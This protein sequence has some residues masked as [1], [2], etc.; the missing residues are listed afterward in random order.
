MRKAF[1]LMELAIVLTIM[2]ILV[3]G[4]MGIMGSMMKNAKTKQTKDNI[5]AAVNSIVG[6]V[7]LNNNLPDQTGFTNSVKIPND[8]WSKPFVYIYPNILHDNNICYAQTTDLSIRECG[9][10]N[11]CTTYAQKDNIAFVVMSGGENYNLQ[12]T[13]VGGNP[14][15][16]RVYEQETNVDNIATPIN[17]VEPY[18]DIVKW[19]TLSELQAKINCKNYQLKIIN[20]D[21]PK[22]NVGIPYSAQLFANN[23]IQY[24]SGGQYRWCVY[25]ASSL[26]LNGVSMSGTA[27]RSSDDCLSQNESVWVQSDNM[28][29]SGTPTSA[30]T[31]LIKA[32]VSDNNQAGNANPIQ[33]G[34]DKIYQ[35]SLVLTV[36]P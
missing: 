21:I 24:S 6:H 32:Y 11:T 14:V 35:T 31:Y 19:V 34:N 25:D 1:S 13:A 22:A 5:E 26:S 23:G 30:G 3:G 4:S 16:V 20:G 27:V 12:T 29:F 8:A 17:R 33:S 7:M 9:Y 2:G 36:D 10:D 15:Y 28:S 18:D